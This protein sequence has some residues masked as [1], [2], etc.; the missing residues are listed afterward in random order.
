MPGPTLIIHGGAGAREGSHA[1]FERYQRSLLTIRQQAWDVLQAD[2]AQAAV[3]AAVRLLEDDPVFNA[4]LGSRLQRDGIA[5]MSAALM[6]GETEAFAGVINIE[7]VRHPIDVAAALS[8]ARHSVLAGAHATAFARSLGMPEFDPITEHRLQ[9]HRQQLAGETGTVGAIA[10]D[11]DG[12]LCAGTST[13]GVGHEIPGRVSDSA[14]VAGTYASRVAGVSC[15]GVGEHI[16]NHGAAVRIVT[17]IEDGASLQ[18]AVSR[19][20]AEADRRQLEYGLIAL[21]HSGKSIAACTRNMVTL[22]ASRE[23]TSQG[24]RNDRDFLAG[25]RQTC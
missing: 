11:V 13:G 7:S 23:L 14:T 25:A 16:V 9:E 4:G 15:T 6:D 3:L 22:F 1:S 21:D 5:R 12:G 24:Q 18:Q 2:G 17:R 8:G 10:L 19:T 20:I